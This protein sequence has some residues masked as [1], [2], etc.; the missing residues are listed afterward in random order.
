MQVSK[1][2][3]DRQRHRHRDR[4]GHRRDRH[5]LDRLV[6]EEAGVVADEL[7]GVDE[8]HSLMPSSASPTA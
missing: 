3:P 2:E 1:P 5:V 6:P 8:G 4:D 7:E